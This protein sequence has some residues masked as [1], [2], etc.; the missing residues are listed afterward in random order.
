MTDATQPTPEVAV[1]ELTPEQA[2]TNF[3]WYYGKE[4]VFNLQTTVR[5]ILTPGQIEHHIHT[6]K[7]TMMAVHRIGGHPR[8][9]KEDRV[10]TTATAAT[11]PFIPEN[12]SHGQSV[13][14][15]VEVGTAFKSGNTQLKFH[16]DGMEHPLTFTKAVGEMAKL[17]APLNIPAE[18]IVVGKKF[19][20]NA[21]VSWEQ[22]D[23]YKNVLAVTPR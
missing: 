15:M 17:L 12:G 20:V 10:Q 9:T 6:V 1:P 5:G 3:Y 4:E 23:K 14:A 11:S 7:Q 22:V 18:Q 16:C 13:C 8:T 19:P 21:T 2:S